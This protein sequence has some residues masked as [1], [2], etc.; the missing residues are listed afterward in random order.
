M[1]FSVGSPYGTA[2]LKYFQDQRNAALERSYTPF[3]KGGHLPTLFS[4]NPDLVLSK[5]SLTRD[6]RLHVPSYT[7]FNLDS[8]RSAQ[9][10][11][12][13]QVGCPGLG[14]CL[15]SKAGRQGA[16]LEAMGGPEETSHP[17][18]AT[19]F[20]FLKPRPSKEPRGLAQCTGDEAQDSASWMPFPTASW[21]SC[22]C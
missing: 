13:Y 6:R 11:G 9:I 19:L 7:R 3:S 4:S 22:P 8:D 21:G 16:G 18:R 10:T 2:T 12:F 5:R 15:L 17:Q 20:T 1:A 14:C